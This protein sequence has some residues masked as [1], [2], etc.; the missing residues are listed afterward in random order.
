MK[1]IILDRDGTINQDFG[2]VHKVEDL[3]FLDNTLI[4]LKKM[5]TLDYKLILAT[6]QSG[7]SRGYYTRDQYEE[8]N[9]NLIK[10]LE[11]NEIKIITSFYCPHQ[12]NDNCCCR[13]PKTGMLDQFINENNVNLQ[14]SYVIGDK[15]SDIMLGHNLRTKSIL[16]L[17]G[18][19][20]QDK[21]FDVN[22]D[23]IVAD[24]LEAAEKIKKCLLQKSKI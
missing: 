1:I 14:E 8:F 3:V 9:K 13:K 18:M 22:P 7:I 10:K 17:T 11:E 6:N 24:L 5:Q 4:G 19:A 2:F 12:P 20:G 23:Y 15:S 21:K 16:V